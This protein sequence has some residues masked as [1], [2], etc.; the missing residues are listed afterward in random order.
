[1]RSTKSKPDRVLPNT[2]ALTLLSPGGK[3]GRLE[4]S[5]HQAAE[6]PAMQRSLG[7]ELHADS[8]Y[9]RND[10]EDKIFSQFVRF[11]I[12]GAT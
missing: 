2:D 4:M 6:V 10:I 12:A 1:M 8:T 3:R 5:K 11:F 7:I 9:T